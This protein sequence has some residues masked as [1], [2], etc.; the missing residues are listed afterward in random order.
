[1]NELYYKNKNGV[2]FEINFLNADVPN[3]A[4]YF[5]FHIKV[6][7]ISGDNKGMDRLYKALVTKSVCQSE[8]G[9]IMWLTTSGY[10]F[11]KEILETFNNGKT[12]ILLP[13]SK[14]WFIM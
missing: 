5:G 8:Q 2:D 13:P 3:D 9:A 12:L 1:M 11:L 10:D 7:V 4:D 6:K 14:D